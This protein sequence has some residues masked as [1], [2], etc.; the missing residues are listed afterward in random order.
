MAMGYIKS[1]FTEPGSIVQ[2]EILGS[3]YNATIL[4]EPLYDA[5]GLR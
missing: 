3:F 1:E 5:S 4:S 2:V